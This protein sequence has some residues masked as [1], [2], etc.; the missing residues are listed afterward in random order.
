MRR[1]VLV[2]LQ[3]LATGRPWP[4][5]GHGQNLEALRGRRGSKPLIQAHA[6]SAGSTP[7]AASNTAV[8]PASNWTASVGVNTP[9]RRRRCTAPRTPPDW[10]TRPSCRDRRPPK[11]QQGES[12]TLGQREEPGPKSP[13]TSPVVSR[14]SRSVWSRHPRGSAGHGRVQGSGGRWHR[15]RRT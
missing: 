3:A 1:S 15:S 5:K 10:T 4:S 13:R 12:D 14:S 9:S 7:L 8:S 2:Q 11:P 6:S